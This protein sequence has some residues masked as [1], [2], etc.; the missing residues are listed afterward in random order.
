MERIKQLNSKIGFGLF[1]I[2]IIF[3]GLKGCVVTIWKSPQEPTTY[4][5]HGKDGRSL[6]MLFMP[7]NETYIIYT[8]Q[9]TGFIEVILTKM[10]GTF[11][12]HYFWRLWSLDGP[13]TGD[14]LF[15]YRIYP[16]GARPVVMETTVKNK[17]IHGNGN[18]TLRS[19][20]DRTHPVILFTENSVRFE[21]MWLQKEPTNLEFL[22]T[23]NQRLKNSKQ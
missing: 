9:S 20:G 13:G 18:P 16:E 1:I 14:G 10:R 6:S 12:T 17:F 21:D 5:V 8:E 22:S 3:F 4:A 7:K 11:G 19:I 23:L 2:F 15:G